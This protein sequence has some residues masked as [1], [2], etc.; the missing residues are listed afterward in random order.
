M[1]YFSG[2]SLRK[3][4]EKIE[5]NSDEVIF[6]V[7]RLVCPGCEQQFEDWLGR[8]S[9]AALKLSGFLDCE[10]ILPLAERQDT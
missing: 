3:L 10:A 5:S 4:K 2:E 8:M 1:C 6:V 7:T 9:E